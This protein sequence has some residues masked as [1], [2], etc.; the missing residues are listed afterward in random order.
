[1]RVTKL[2]STKQMG[3]PPIG[4]RAMTAA[5]KQRRYRERKFG[6]RPPVTKP[7]AA[8]AANLEARIRQLEAGLVHERT[9]I[10]MLEAGL[11]AA[12]RAERQRVESPKASKPLLPPDEARDRRI[13]ALTTQVRN[14]RT[15]LRLAKNYF[16]EEIAKT[17]GM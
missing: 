2:R 17:G 10:K 8:A 5:E 7:S 13:K 4:E 11:Q 3:R 9:R 15:E 1:M 12:R 6:N 14:L 16:D